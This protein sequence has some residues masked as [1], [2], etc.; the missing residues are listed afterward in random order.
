MKQETYTLQISLN[1]TKMIPQ[2]GWN[3]QISE[4]SHKSQADRGAVAV[5]IDDGERKAETRWSFDSKGFETAWR[6][7]GGRRYNPENNAYEEVYFSGWSI[8]LDSIDERRS[9]NAA[10]TITCTILKTP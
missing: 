7:V 8:R 1:E 9:N 6:G 10:Q 4:S 5:L 3:I 2:L